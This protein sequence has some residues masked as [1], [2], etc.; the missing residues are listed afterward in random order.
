MKQRIPHLIRILL[1]VMMLSVI[2]L[3]VV[4]VP[5]TISYLETFTRGDGIGITAVAY[6]LAAVITL[7]ALIVFIIAFEFPKT[8]EKDCVFTQRTAVLLKRIASLILIDCILF[9]T[10]IVF[11]MV[12]GETILSPALAFFDVIGV[13]LSALLF[14]LS[15]YIKEAAQL[16]E[17]A[18]YT[19]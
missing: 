18:E 2:L 1:V 17:E 14:I 12:V 19:L 9:A 5:D 16:K 4:W 6:V 11:L 8:I 3:A 10:G 7:I 15:G 13:V